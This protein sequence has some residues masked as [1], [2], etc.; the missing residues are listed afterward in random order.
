MFMVWI[1]VPYRMRPGTLLPLF[2]I[3]IL[4]GGA[5]YKLRDEADDGEPYFLKSPT[6]ISVVEGEMAVLK[7]IISN[8]GPKMVNVVVWRRMNEDF[9]LTIGKVTFSQVDDMSVQHT[10]LTATTSA[11]DLLIKNVKPSHAG[12]YECQ[13]S[14]N[15]LIAQYVTLNVIE[16]S[17]MQPGKKSSKIS[18]VA[19]YSETGTIHVVPELRII[20]NNYV[21]MGSL[22]HLICNATGALRTPEAVDWFYEGNRIDQSDSRWQGRVEILKHESFEGRYYV[23]ELIV[24]KTDMGDNGD[25]VCRSSD[26][27]V[28]SVKVH[29]LNAVKDNL[30]I[31]GSGKDAQSESIRTN[32]ASSAFPVYIEPLPVLT[33]AIIALV[34]S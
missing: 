27:A 34:W 26:L 5:T 6:N 10:E 24:D 20:G 13:V 15:H 7:C 31:R 17:S 18:G 4:H 3:C 30:T 29:I 23:S 2:L 12:L 22:L 28:N 14:A 21:N 16:K 33:Y 32:P 11:W 19:T 1:P 8:L 25:Y 9:P